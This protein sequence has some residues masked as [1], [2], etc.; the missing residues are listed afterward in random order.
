MSKIYKY[1]L[2]IVLVLMS[3]GRAKAD[4]LDKFHFER[5]I[6]VTHLSTTGMN[7]WVEVSSEWAHTLIVK[8]GKVDVM[9]HGNKVATIELRDKVVIPRRA[10]SKVLIPLRFTTTNSFTLQRVLRHL[11]D[12]G[13]LGTTID[14]RIRAGLKVLK[15]NFSDKNV[16]V[17]EILDNFALSNENLRELIALI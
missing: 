2:L 11:I 8:K 6:T 16:A 3:V 4:V 12:K 7:L 5:F 13:G 17:S 1:S 10:K 9:M 15:V 14:Y